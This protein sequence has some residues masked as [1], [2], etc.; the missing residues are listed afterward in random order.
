MTGAMYAA[1]GGLRS[2]MSKLNVIGNNIANVNTFG[3][4]SQRM[5]F[6]ES[7]YGTSRSGSNG[8]TVSGGNNPSQIG[9]GCSV[10]T[11][12]LN[13]SPST[14][15]PT[16]VQMDC[17]IDG[18]GFFMVGDK[19]Q[20]E[21]TYWM[22][23]EEI[24]NAD[25]PPPAGTEVGSVKSVTWKGGVTSGSELKDYDLTRVG[26]F[27]VDPDGYICNGDGKVLYG[28]ARVQNPD[29]VPGASKAEIALAK[30][31]GKDIESET[32]IST[33]LV[34]L[35]V[36]LQAAIPTRENGGKILIKD[37]QPVETQPKPD[38]DY[39][40]KEG[41][42][43]KD[44]WEEGDPV[45]PY[46]GEDGLNN[47]ADP[48]FP[49]VRQ[50]APDDAGGGGGGG[51]ADQVTVPNGPGKGWSRVPTAENT[52]SDAVS[53]VMPCQLRGMGI[54]K[55]GSIYG[56]ANGKT[57]VIGYIAI[58]S[59]D[60]PNGVTHTGGPYYKCMPGAGNLR[61]SSLGIDLPNAYLGN[62]LP[63]DT[64]ANDPNID[65]EIASANDKIWNEK[66]TQ[67]QSQGLEASGTDLAYEFAEMVTTQ[68]GYQ[69]NTRIVNVTDSMLEELVNMKR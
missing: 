11:I 24:N 69:A 41:E 7:I 51:G 53:N 50:E 8:N 36:P 66:S 68:R 14:Y 27:W 43:W 56:T 10:G 60:N 12:D 47:Y 61:V 31:Q 34:P 62:K 22:S 52:A 55:D 63:P 19:L 26:D 25:P 1:I 42:S 2:H 21:V 6:K 15:S 39:E 23:Q 33:H 20:R 65:G 9:Y 17:Y 45:Y 32:I 38:E 28:Y 59:A 29:Y 35:R 16:G 4:K 13:M 30:T 48:D 54:G 37:G 18:D 44:L 46:L 67:L 5:T 58:A 57:V 64:D 40:L 49:K 3:Y